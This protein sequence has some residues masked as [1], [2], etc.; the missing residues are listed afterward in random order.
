[1][2]LATHHQITRRV[3]MIV[4][5]LTL[6]LIVLA[7]F[8]INDLSITVVVSIGIIFFIKALE[9][10]INLLYSRLVPMPEIKKVREI[11]VTD[12][13]GRGVRIIVISQ[14]TEFN[15]LD[16]QSMK[17][18]DNIVALAADKLRESKPL[19]TL[20]YDFVLER[21]LPMHYSFS[22]CGEKNSGTR[23][24]YKSWLKSINEKDFGMWKENSE[25]FL[26]DD[27]FDDPETGEQMSSLVLFMFDSRLPKTLKNNADAQ[28][29]ESKDAET[30]DAESKA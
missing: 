29:A 23:K 1:M 19:F 2:F 5:V 28:D 30:K 26:H 25:L 27:F 10:Y 6:A 21:E 20:R 13:P 8:L 16:S 15:L 11:N 14:F 9:P 17:L 4:S 24:C 18:F 7:Y 3:V 22:V 12:E